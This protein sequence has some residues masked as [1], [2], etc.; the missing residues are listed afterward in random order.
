MKRSTKM[1]LAPSQTQ[2][3]VTVTIA[4]QLMG[5]TMLTVLTARALWQAPGQVATKLYKTHLTPRPLKTPWA[6]L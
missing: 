2:L 5:M 4:V 3:T 6:T 1:Q